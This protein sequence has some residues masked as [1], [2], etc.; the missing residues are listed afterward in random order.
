MRVQAAIEKKN[1]LMKSIKKESEIAVRNYKKELE[2]QY[3]NQ[4]NKV[5]TPF[6]FD[7]CGLGQEAARVPRYEWPAGRRHGCA[8]A[9]VR[10]EQRGCY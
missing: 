1:E 10:A 2:E 8:R 4:L 3:D 7:I 9:G 6:V 5:S